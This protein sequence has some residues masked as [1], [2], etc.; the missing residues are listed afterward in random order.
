MF[1]QNSKA[2]LCFPSC[3]HG[4]LCVLTIVVLKT[5]QCPQWIFVVN[6]DVTDYL[7][8]HMKLH[9]ILVLRIML[10]TLHLEL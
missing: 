4:C 2:K 8:T 7:K 9:L 10:L 1:I 3:D 5:P 6:T